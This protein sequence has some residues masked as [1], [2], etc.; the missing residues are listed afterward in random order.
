MNY[1]R[2]LLTLVLLG[3]MGSAHF[4]KA[5]AQTCNCWPSQL[6]FLTSGVSSSFTYNSVTHT[7]LSAYEGTIIQS[8]GAHYNYHPA[9]LDT[10]SCSG[11]TPKAL[12]R[13]WETVNIT[14]NQYNDGIGFYYFGVNGLGTGRPIPQYD[15][16]VQINPASFGLALVADP[17][18]IEINPPAGT[19]IMYFTGTTD[20]TGQTN[21]KVYRLT[22]T[23]GSTWT[24]PAKVMLSETSGWGIGQPS[25]IYGVKS[26]L[27]EMWATDNTV[28]QIK[29]ATSTDGVNWTV[30][31]TSGTTAL[32]YD[33]RL[34][35]YV[36]LD[37]NGDG[38]ITLSLSAN[39]TSWTSLP[40]AVF[41]VSNPFFPLTGQYPRGIRVLRNPSGLNAGSVSGSSFSNVLYF[42]TVNDGNPFNWSVGRG[43]A[44]IN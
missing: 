40:S 16:A 3:L 12:I 20:S 34:S 24:G 21:N 29:Y 28:H 23:D 31:G 36:A 32:T 33:S 17:N 10:C 39:G 5:S 18:V 1:N 44:T 30:Q 13:Y 26:G 25:V 41:Q 27:W 6:P 43:E 37:W 8:D 19:Y 14:A 22:S 35:A 2:R 4:F 42:F 38:G 15:I 7:M 9:V 11:G